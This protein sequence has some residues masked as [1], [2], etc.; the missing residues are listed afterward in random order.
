MDKT[1]TATLKLEQG[2]LLVQTPYSE[3]LVAR[4]KEMVPWQERTWQKPAW[5]VKQTHLELIRKLLSEVAGE[6]G[7]QL[8]D[9]TA[10]LEQAIEAQ[11]RTIAQS[12]LDRHVAA[13]VQVLPKLPPRALRLVDWQEEHL[14]FELATFLNDSVLFKELASASLE[15]YRPTI[16]Y[17]GLY[18]REFSHTFVIAADERILRALCTI[19]GITPLSDEHGYRSHVEYFVVRQL[20]E[21]HVF[22]DGIAHFSGEDGSFWIG[23]P[24]Q[25]VSLD[26][27][28]SREAWQVALVDDRLYLLFEREKTVRKLVAVRE[29]QYVNP[30]FGNVAV[31]TSHPSQVAEF[32]TLSH[33]EAWFQAWGNAL[34]QV[35]TVKAS[36]YASKPHWFS[37]SFDHPAEELLHHG[38]RSRSGS[39]E[40]WSILGWTPEY[41]RSRLEHIK[42]LKEQAAQRVIDDMRV[43]SAELAL[44]KLES[45]TVK[46]LLELGTKYGIEVKKSWGKERIVQAFGTSVQVCEDII[47]LTKRLEG[48]S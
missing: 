18:K 17:G 11:K 40:M 26:L 36:P 14:T 22:E 10:Q 19:A 46:D 1:R 38:S 24:Y 45:L 23:I 47:G 28:W 2:W 5:K 33:S 6:E 3:L 20:T 15:A 41:I 30:G 35:E 21:L 37:G 29:S 16:L 12:D 25:Q 32:V 4:L 31:A 44:P 27:S 8:L 39:Q 48:R 34:A 7:W 13:V 9:Y 42:V 43:H